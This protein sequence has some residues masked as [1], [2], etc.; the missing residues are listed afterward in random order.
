MKENIMQ[1]KEIN[2]KNYVV[3]CMTYPHDIAQMATF[4]P[5][6]FGGVYNIIVSYL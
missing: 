6:F 1:N 2:T 3:W 4:C 5:Y